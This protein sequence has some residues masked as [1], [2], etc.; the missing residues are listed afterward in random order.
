MAGGCGE[1]DPRSILGKV[2]DNLGGIAFLGAFVIAPIGIGSLYGIYGS[3]GERTELTF[4]YRGK[5]A[6][7]VRKDLRFA[8]DQF[9]IR[10]GNGNVSIL[11]GSI[12][13]DDG[14]TISVG[15]NVPNYRVRP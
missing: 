3:R 11:E 9:E 13:A 12:L 1:G 8:P 4:N 15:K 14:R 5:N 7:I 6:S 10:I 2:R